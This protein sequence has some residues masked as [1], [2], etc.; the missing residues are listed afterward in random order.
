MALRRF[1]IDVEGTAP[2]LLSS[3]VS[4]DPLS[5]EAKLRKHFTSKKSK[6][7]QDH[8]NL[9]ILDWVYSGYWSLPGEVILDEAENALNFEGY[10]NLYL[11]DQN[12]ARCLRNGATA[13][14]LGK[15]VTRAVIIENNPLIEYDGPDTAEEMWNAR[16]FCHNAPTVRMGKTNWVSRIVI[17]AGWKCAYTAIVDDEKITPEQLGNICNAAGRFEGLGTW[18]P[19]FGRFTSVINEIELD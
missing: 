9:R 17:P 10:G 13:W 2:L 12:F 3:N 8:I 14:R 6:V 16:R 15:D 7:D 1:Q 18:R 5:S 19:R 4:S 11:P